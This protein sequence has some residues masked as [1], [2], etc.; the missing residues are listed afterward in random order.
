MGVMRQTARGP[1]VAALFVA[2]ALLPSAN[3]LPQYFAWYD[4]G[5]GPLMHYTADHTNLRLSSTLEQAGAAK[6]QYQQASLLAVESVLWHN[7]NGERG[8][9]LRPDVASAWAAVAPVAAQLLANHSIIGFNL[10]DE[11]VWNCLPP[12]ELAAGVDLIRQTFPR[13]SGPSSAVI[14]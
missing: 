4:A 12:A 7:P 5:S 3:P 14:W 13:A 11:L 1:I 10:G 8:F 9:R 2:S 6:T